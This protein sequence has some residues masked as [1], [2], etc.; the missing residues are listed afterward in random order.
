MFSIITAITATLLYLFALNLLFRRIRFNSVD[1]YK[2]LLLK[3]IPVAITFHLLSLIP[4]FFTEHGTINFSLALSISFIA[5]GTVIAL[6]ITNLNKNTGI[7]GIF[8]LPLAAISPLLPF[9]YSAETYLTYEIG[10]HILLSISA[11]SVL[12]LA[13]AQAILYGQQEKR[14]HKRQLSILFKS[15]PPLQVMEKTLI[16]FTIIGFILLSLSLIS[17]GFYIENMFSQHL[18][19]KTFFSVL[20]WIVYAI[21]L[22]GHFKKGWRGQKAAK[23]IFWAYMLLLLSYLGVETILLILNSLQ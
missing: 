12:G 22:F 4:Q 21:F 8:I 3:I 13:A 15:L 11:Y 14:F 2:S 9:G 19:H 18:I 7:L 16:Q 17:G 6:F 23:F 20:S 1:L 10:S 5:L